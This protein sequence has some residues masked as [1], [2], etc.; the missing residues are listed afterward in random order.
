MLFDSLMLI[1]GSLLE[2]LPFF[3]NVSI[4]MLKCESKNIYGNTSNNNVLL[5]RKISQISPGMLQAVLADFC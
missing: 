3:L 2:L 1:G 5:R 4:K